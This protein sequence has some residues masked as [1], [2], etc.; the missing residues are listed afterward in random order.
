MGV[1]A[2]PP[3]VALRASVKPTR[4]YVVEVMWFIRQETDARQEPLTLL[5][6]V[7]DRGTREAIFPLLLDVS[8]L[9]WGSL[10]ACHLLH[11]VGVGMASFSPT[12]SIFWRFKWQPSLQAGAQQC[13]TI[14]DLLLFLLGLTYTSPF[15]SLNCRAC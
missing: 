7:Y 2:P 15:L 3:R 14:S 10:F 9:C 8:E 1:R 4:G 11:F 5:F 13:D 6:G 12:A